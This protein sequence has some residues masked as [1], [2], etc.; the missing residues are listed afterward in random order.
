V[1]FL[2]AM[3]ST[4][5]VRTLKKDIARYN[6]LEQFALEDFGE[7]DDVED[8]VAEDSGWKLVHGDIF[9]PPKNPLFLSV[10]VGNGAQLFAMTALTIGKSHKIP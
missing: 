5:L 10:L 6:R 9:R 7:N 4:I 1:V 2:V 8:G 3:V